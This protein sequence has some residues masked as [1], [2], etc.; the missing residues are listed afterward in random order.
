MTTCRHSAAMACLKS[1]VIVAFVLQAA[2]QAAAQGSVQRPTKRLELAFLVGTSSPSV[3]VDDPG[4]LRTPPAVRDTGENYLAITQDVIGRIYWTRRMCTIVGVGW[5]TE[6]SREYV[7]PKPTSPPEFPF[8]D[9]EAERVASYR[10]HLIDVSQGW[11]LTGG[12]VVPYVGGGAEL[13]SV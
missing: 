13:R 4:G 2:A 6:E 11:D 12:R 3:V 1:A 9:Y 10:N 7:F 8:T 5:S